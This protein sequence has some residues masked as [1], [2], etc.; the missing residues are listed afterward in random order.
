MP[1]IFT[2]VPDNS[3]LN[4]YEPY[5]II[6]QTHKGFVYKSQLTGQVSEVNTSENYE[7]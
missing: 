2:K 3:P 1:I 6:N 5:E 7:Y 4:A